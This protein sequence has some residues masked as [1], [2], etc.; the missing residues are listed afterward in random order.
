MSEGGEVGQVPGKACGLGFVP[1]PAHSAALQA[2]GI[3]S[4]AFLDVSLCLLA[5][6]STALA[7]CLLQRPMTSPGLAS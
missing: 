2:I 3:L 5:R 6:V 1:S 4:P 7:L